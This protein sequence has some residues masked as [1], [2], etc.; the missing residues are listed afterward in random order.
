MRTLFTMLAAGLLAFS[1][2]ASADAAMKKKKHT[3]IEASC[4]AQAANKYSA[5]HFMKRRA[6]VKQCVGAAKA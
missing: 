5:V 3:S 1:F 6:Y 2:D 4:K